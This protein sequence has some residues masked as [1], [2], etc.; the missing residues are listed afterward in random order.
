ME[1][2]HYATI[3]QQHR[4]PKT[5]DAY[6]FISTREVLD[7]FAELGWF[8]ARVQEA[9]VRK[10][11]NFGFQGHMVRL[12]NPTFHAREFGVG[13]CKGQIVLKNA[14]NGQ[15]SFHLYAGL[16]ELVCTNGLVVN[17]K[18]HVSIPHRG[19]AVWM[20]SA[21]VEQIA[22]QFRGAF[23]ERERWRGIRLQRDEQ[24]AFADAAI[25]LRFDR[26]AVEVDPA[27]VLTPRRWEQAEPSL[28]H[29]FNTVQE[30]ILR[31]GVRQ[32]RTDGSQFRSR[33]VKSIDEDLR[34]NRALWLLAQ[35]LERAVQ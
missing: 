20:V 25:S 19:Y 33:A 16:L 4:H 23:E 27:E 2:T 6:R 30:S 12:E 22:R 26:Q 17:R 7:T 14:H 35:D 32:V 10:P 28:W 3:L 5:T 29:V 1:L 21:A 34:I 31:G 18:E 11:E 13:D 24:L 9:G 8:P 15:S